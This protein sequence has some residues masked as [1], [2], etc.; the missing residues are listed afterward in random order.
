[1]V[2]AKRNNI[3]YFK[4]CC[5]LEACITLT[6]KGWVDFEKCYIYADC[7]TC[8]SDIDIIKASFKEFEADLKQLLSFLLGTEKQ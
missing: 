4:N 6:E 5:G 7:V 3:E 8:Q 2:S 1:M